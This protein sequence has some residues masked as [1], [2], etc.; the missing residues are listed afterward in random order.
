[1]GTYIPNDG[2]N[3]DIGVQKKTKSGDS[4]GDSSMILGIVALAA[5]AFF[6]IKMKKKK[7]K[8]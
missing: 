8:K 4:S 7:K 2:Q 1:M 3:N 5:I 6:L